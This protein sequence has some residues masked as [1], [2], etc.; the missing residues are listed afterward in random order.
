MRFSLGKHR[1][2]QTALVVYLVALVAWPAFAEDRPQS[3]PGETVTESN[4]QIEQRVPD[5]AK[6]PAGSEMVVRPLEPRLPEDKGSV[7]TDAGADLPLAT[8]NAHE[9]S[10]L[11]AARAAVEAS[12]LA[13]TLHS[14][15]AIPLQRAT[16]A[17]ERKLTDLRNQQ[18]VEIAAPDGSGVLDAPPARQEVGPAGLNAH[19]QAKLD[20]QPHGA[21]LRAEPVPPTVAAPAETRSQREE[22]R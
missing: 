6:R 21:P 15:P 1:L 4:P 20:G 8:P 18:P 9:L 5:A 2:W 17:E 14:A 12:R 3:G 10:K 19:E 13:G 16:D 22:G 11:E 7:V